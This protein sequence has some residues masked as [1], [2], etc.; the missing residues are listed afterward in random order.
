MWAV[1]GRVYTADIVPAIIN[2]QSLFLFFQMIEKWE[3]HCWNDC[4]AN[5]T[6]HTPPLPCLASC[7]VED[8]MLATLRRVKTLNP[9]VSTVFYL[10]SL[11]AFP[12]YKLTGQYA[13]AGALLEDANTKSPIVLKNDNGMPDIYVFDFGS[14]QGRGL[15]LNAVSASVG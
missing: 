6:K 7:N 12:F 9:S 11:L 10:N 15:W 8:D 4:L 14:E 13:S 5:A 1:C 2:A 3:G